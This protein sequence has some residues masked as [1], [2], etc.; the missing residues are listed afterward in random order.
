MN[1]ASSSYAATV[2]TFSG[3]ATV[4]T[5]AAGEAS[6]F[7]ADDGTWAQI[8]GGGNDDGWISVLDTWTYASAT[9]ITVPSGAADIYS[10]G[11]PWKL[12]ANSVDLEGYIVGV[13]D[14][15]LTVIG[16]DLTN[17]AFSDIAY[18]KSPNPVG[19]SVWFDYTTVWSGFSVDPTSVVS[20]YRVV[21]KSCLVVL[22]SNA[23]GTSNATTMSAT[24]PINTVTTLRVPAMVDNNGSLQVAG[25][26]DVTGGN[27]NVYRS[28][29]TAFTTSGGKRVYPTSVE[30]PIA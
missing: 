19:F 30:Y 23:T 2:K 21:G 8:G 18:S 7:V 9:T 13:A 27:F 10:V 22:G 20:K 1:D 28:Q 12:T 26:A 25:F 4:A 3:A 16:D 11:D 5:L 15:L 17:H 6:L 24:L 14:T 29:A